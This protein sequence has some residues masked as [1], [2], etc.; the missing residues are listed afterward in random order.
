MVEGNMS[1]VAQFA[2]SL[3]GVDIVFHTAAHFRDSYKGGKHWDELYRT[4]V[5]G[6]ADLISAAYR[7]GIRRFVHTSSIAV[8][9][10]PPGTQIDETMLREESHA[11]D[12]YRSKILSD[13]EVLGFLDTHPDMWA[14]MVLP[15]WMHGPGDI[16]PDLRG[17][18]NARLPEGQASR[19]HPRQLFAGGRAR[20]GAGIDLGG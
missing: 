20:R 19:R 10:G 17:P 7:A 13:K 11:D 14:A 1:D 6:T 12:Y 15:E 9:D 3:E 4:N 16:G 18:D 8:L 5:R 2:G